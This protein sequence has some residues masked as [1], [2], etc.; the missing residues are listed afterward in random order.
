MYS[1]S[2]AQTQFYKATPAG[3]VLYLTKLSLQW[4]TF[5]TPPLY[6]LHLQQQCLATRLWEQPSMSGDVTTVA[7]TAVSV[8]PSGKLVEG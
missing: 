5:T 1:N 8:M 6:A 3:R 2:R 4:H 7:V